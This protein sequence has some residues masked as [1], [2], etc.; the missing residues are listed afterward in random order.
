VTTTPTQLDNPSET[1][2]R[3]PA[4]GGKPLDFPPHPGCQLCPLY[5]AGCK[6]VG[7]PTRA[8]WEPGS[9]SIEYPQPSQ[10]TALLVVG[11]APGYEEDMAG[12][13][14]IGRSGS[15]LT[16]FIEAAQLVRFADVYLGNACRCRPLNNATPT[17]GQI[18]A[19]RTWL[20]DDYE[21]L[22]Q[23]YRHLVLFA[24]GAPAAV[25]CGFSTLTK[26]LEH[27]GCLSEMFPDNPPVFSS[28]HPAF[29]LSGRSP[30]KI[31][32]VK[33]HWELLARYLGTGSLFRVD[34]PVS[35]DRR[36]PP[37]GYTGPDLPPPTP[38]HYRG[39][40]YDPRPKNHSD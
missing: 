6:H 11:E 22:Q 24:Q 8:L 10:P 16:K 20:L 21:T 3:F 34:H 15:M 17:K 38:P 23:H 7:V 18:K 1:Y 19:C 39:A 35:Y 2:H 30:H 25:A 33:V 37:P 36:L 5:E 14:W 29:L 40:D 4:K 13:G 9:E 26:A 32:A 28:Y 12:R 31:H 27:Q